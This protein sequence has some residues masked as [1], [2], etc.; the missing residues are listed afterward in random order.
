MKSS[1]GRSGPLFSNIGA[2]SPG[3]KRKNGHLQG[4][5]AN[6]PCA[7]RHNKSYFEWEG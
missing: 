3:R 4:R 2:R 1:P 6:R 5:F 7:N